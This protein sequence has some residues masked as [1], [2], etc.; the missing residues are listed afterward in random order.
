[1]FGLKLRQRTIA[2][3]DFDPAVLNRPPVGEN[4]TGAVVIEVPLLNPDAWLGFGAAD[5]A[6]DA[7]GL[8]AEWES[9]ATRADV[10]RAYYGAVLAAEKVETLEAA[11]EA[12][13][14]H[15]RQAELMVEQGMVTKS[16]ALLAEVKAGEVEA[17]LASARG[18][19]RSAVRQL[20]TLLG[21]PED[22]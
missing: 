12:A 10:V 21:T 6:G 19:A 18:E 16:D 4:W 22:L 9:Y 8:A 20:A 11:M 2:P 17:Q 13:R 15:V 14:A 5:R 7:A 1:A 3:A